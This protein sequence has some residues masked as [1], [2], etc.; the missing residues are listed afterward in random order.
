MIEFGVLCSKGYGKSSEAL[1]SGLFLYVPHYFSFLSLFSSCPAWAG[2]SWSRYSVR[3]FARAAKMAEVVTRAPLL[4][5]NVTS[6]VAG[7]R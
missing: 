3:D 6:R 4:W 7:V 1:A 5:G 2:F